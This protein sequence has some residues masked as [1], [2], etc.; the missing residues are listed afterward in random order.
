MAKTRVYASDRLGTDP[1][2]RLIRELAMPGIVAQVINM[3]YN[4][5]DR[6]YIARIPEVGSMAL[7]GLGIVMPLLMVFGAFSAFTTSGGAPLASIALGAGDQ[8]RAE[9]LLASNAGLMAVL[10]VLMTSLGLIFKEPLIYFF[11]GTEANFVYADEYLSIYLLGTIFVLG[12]LGL[13]SFISA[14]GEAKIAMRTIMIGAISN[15]I[16]DPIFIFAFRMGVKGAALATIISQFISFTT[17]VSFLVSKN[18]KLR[19]RGLG[20]NPG[21]I[22][23]SVKLGIAGFVMSATQSAVVTVFNRLLAFHG[24]DLHV[25][26]MVVLQSIIQMIFIP[27]N[28]YIMGVQPLLSYNYGAKQYDRVNRIIKIS[29]ILLVGFAGTISILSI[30]FPGAF[31]V[32]FT[33][34]P[35][36]IALV[37]RYLPIFIAGTTIFGMQMV[38][39]MY[40]VGS[41]QPGFAIFLASLRKVILLI[42]FCFLFAAWWGVIGVYAAEAVA[43]ALSAITSGLL[44]VWH[45]RRMK[46]LREENAEP[47]PDGA[48]S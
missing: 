13:N 30:L 2:G 21:L 34:D 46:K 44:L 35:A 26:T 40:F 36:L 20:F 8:E 31:A 37:R 18:S 42:P 47:Q 7:S 48:G 25:A 39:Q 4:V 33:N 43:D 16:L 12:T 9:K 19:L 28:G 5:V 23:E 10:G 29:A 32:I 24:G 1:L 27:M 45:V 22:W 6:I 17:V 15:I 38:A 3:L 14:Q 41:N 11:G